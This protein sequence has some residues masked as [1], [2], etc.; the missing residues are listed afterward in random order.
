MTP[1]RPPHFFLEGGDQLA[2]D[3]AWLPNVDFKHYPSDFTTDADGRVALPALIPGR[4]TG[5]ATGRLATRRKGF[6][7]ARNSPSSRVRTSNWAISSS[8]N[9]LAPF[10]IK[11]KCHAFDTSLGR[12]M[13]AAADSNRAS[14]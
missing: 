5:S 4:R 6:R 8:R 9:R 7:S 12:M 14:S 11:C 2:A 10:E 3:A 13:D 1:A